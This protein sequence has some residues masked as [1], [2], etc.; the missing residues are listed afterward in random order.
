MREGKTGVFIQQTRFS[1]WEV[2]SESEGEVAPELNGAVRSPEATYSVLSNAYDVRVCTGTVTAKLTA[3]GGDGLKVTVF[4]RNLYRGE[5][6][7]RLTQDRNIET[8]L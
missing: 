5:G 3:L 7:Q 6:G 8:I 4:R 2:G 1:G